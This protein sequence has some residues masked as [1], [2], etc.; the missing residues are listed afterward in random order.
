M[1]TSLVTFSGSLSYARYQTP[2]TWTAAL[3]NWYTKGLRKVL[4][5]A[6]PSWTQPQDMPLTTLKKK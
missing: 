1:L 5:N 4:T 3:V 2:W 6:M